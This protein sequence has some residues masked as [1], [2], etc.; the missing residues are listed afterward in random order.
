MGRARDGSLRVMEATLEGSGKNIQSPHVCPSRV[1]RLANAITVLSFMKLTLVPREQADRRLAG[2]RV[3][4]GGSCCDHKK[5]KK[6][7]KMFYQGVGEG[8]PLQT[9]AKASLLPEV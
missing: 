7:K 9:H 6:Y 8:V 1:E 5:I 4:G 2:K 3:E